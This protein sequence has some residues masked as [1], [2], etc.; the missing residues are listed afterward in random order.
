MGD[1]TRPLRRPRGDTPSPA[2]DRGSGY[3]SISRF[4]FD[5][6]GKERDNKLY[7]VGVKVCVCGTPPQP[8][9]KIFLE[10]RFRAPVEGKG[11]IEGRGGLAPPTQDG[12]RGPTYEEGP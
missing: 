9:P 4:S 2:K 12:L 6:Y 8:G 5:H 3:K 11:G 10:D 7:G 1:P